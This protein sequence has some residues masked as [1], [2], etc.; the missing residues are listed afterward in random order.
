MRWSVSFQSTF[1]LGVHFKF[2]NEFQS[3]ANNNYFSM[4]SGAV[5]HF[6]VLAR[7]TGIDQIALWD[8]PMGLFWVRYH[9]CNWLL[10]ICGSKFVVHREEKSLRHVAMVVKFLDN[11]KP[12]TSLKVNSHWFKIHQSYSISFNLSNVSEIF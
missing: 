10:R 2:G 7:E 4:K 9:L 11:N 8:G 12:K 3:R 5:G 6:E 1:D